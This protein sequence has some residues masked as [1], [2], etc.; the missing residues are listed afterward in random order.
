MTESTQHDLL[1]R[2]AT[3]PLDPAH[4]RFRDNDELVDHLEALPNV[5]VEEIG[6]SRLGGALYGVRVGEGDR[7]VSVIAGSHA[8]EPIGPMTAQMLPAVLAQAFPELLEAYQFHIVPQMNPDGA[9]VN[10]TWFEDPPE[11]ETYLRNAVREQP[12]D[13]I[14]FGFGA[15]DTVR[16][17]NQAAM[18]FL[19]AHGPY[20]AHFS[21]HGM[22]YAEG[23]WFL[24]CKEWGSRAEDLMED[25][26]DLCARVKLPLHDIDRGG[27]KGFTRLRPG[28]CT[29]PASVAMRAHFEEAEDLETAAKF[30]PSSMEFV[31]GL[32]GDPLCMV[33]EL[34]LFHIGIP[35]VSLE[36]PVYL[37]F[38]E[39]L[40]KARAEGT[41]EAIQDLA[42]RYRLKPLPLE[43]QIRMQIAMI[44]LALDQV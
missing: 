13:D 16:P 28:F 2:L 43:T 39:S 41:A 34:P 29:T 6:Y 38:K 40:E 27:D 17:E 32:G 44:I 42:R 7:K 24:L 8:D 18:A 22:A 5:Q 26:A 15:G 21:L 3:F 10:R 1:S 31:A 33:S 23:A 30:H 19:S 4:R 25:L 14:E 9:D 35:S 12:G 37:R 20:A 11:L 36:L